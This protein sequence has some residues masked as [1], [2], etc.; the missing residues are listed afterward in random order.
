MYIVKTADTTQECESYAEA[1]AVVNDLVFQ[2]GV[3]D[4]SIMDDKGMLY[5]PKLTLEPMPQQKW[6]NGICC[7]KYLYAQV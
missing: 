2:Y 4:V 7:D 3:P 5:V 1:E 6:L